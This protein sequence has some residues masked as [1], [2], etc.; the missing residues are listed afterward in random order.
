MGV[1]SGRHQLHSGAIRPTHRG[2]LTQILQVCAFD[3]IVCYWYKTA[4]SCAT[5]T[6]EIITSSIREKEKPSASLS[7]N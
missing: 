1:D 6:V 5:D 7:S 3:G 2:T 4:L